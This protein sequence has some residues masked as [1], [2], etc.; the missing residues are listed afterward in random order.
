MSGLLLSIFASCEPLTD[1]GWQLGIKR[2]HTNF[3]IILSSHQPDKGMVHQTGHINTIAAR[4]SFLSF[5]RVSTWQ[6]AVW[7]K[8]ISSTLNFHESIG[9]DRT[10]IQDVL[11]H[12][13][14]L[15]CIDCI[16][17]TRGMPQLSVCYHRKL[18]HGITRVRIHNSRKT[19]CG[20]TSDTDY[21]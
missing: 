12:R 2:D 19:S 20:N 11:H 13:R 14:V 4:V 8:K 6:I 1:V 10:Q 17:L 3:N 7:P 9:I 21:W 16:N 15:L 5:V 18:L